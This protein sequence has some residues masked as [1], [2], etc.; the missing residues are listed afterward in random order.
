MVNEEA[1]EGIKEW[2]FTQVYFLE[3]NNFYRLGEV[4]LT[5]SFMSLG[6]KRM[7]SARPLVFSAWLLRLGDLD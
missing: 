1:G 2:I 6:E 3:T 4:A 5:G 7:A